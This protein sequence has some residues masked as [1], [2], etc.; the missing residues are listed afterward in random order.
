MENSR[1]ASPY[2]E[3]LVLFFH[4]ASVPFSVSPL[5]ILFEPILSDHQRYMS[6]I[7]IKL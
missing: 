5:P 3:A 1:A 6:W 4:Q 7:L 2:L